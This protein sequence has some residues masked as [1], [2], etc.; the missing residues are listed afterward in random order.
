MAEMDLTTEE[1]SVLKEV[2]EAAMADIREE[3]FKAENSHFKE[4]LKQREAVIGRL[5]DRF[6]S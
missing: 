5:L 3:V 2:L 6:G 4:S 1:A